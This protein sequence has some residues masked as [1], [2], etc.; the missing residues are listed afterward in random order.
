MQNCQF[1]RIFKHYEL[2]KCQQTN[3]ICSSVTYLS[4]FCKQF[5]EIRIGW[6]KVVESS[7]IIHVF[8]KKVVIKPKKKIINSFANICIL[9]L[10][11]LLF[12]LHDLEKHENPCK[13][14]TAWKFD[15]PSFY[16]FTYGITLSRYIFFRQHMS[17]EKW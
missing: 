9:V 4:N 15:I 5:F 13:K 2:Y 3:C 6:K 1:F 11:G 12:F 16:C 17:V 14:I 8:W 10:G 7:W